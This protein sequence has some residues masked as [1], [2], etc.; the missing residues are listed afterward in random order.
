MTTAP[1]RGVPISVAIRFM[2]ASV[3]SGPAQTIQDA[4]GNTVHCAAGIATKFINGTPL[5]ILSLVEDG[6]QTTMSMDADQLDQ[7]CHMLADAVHW[8]NAALTPA[9]GS[10]N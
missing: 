10:V 7:F 6:R 3:C 1:S 4:D 2:A 5:I 8:Q 9:T